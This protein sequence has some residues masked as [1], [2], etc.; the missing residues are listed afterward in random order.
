M[1]VFLY[2][3]FKFAFQGFLRNI[4]LSIVTIVILVLTLFS[5][6]TVSGVNFIAEQAIASVREKVDVS[7]YFK[8]A[9]TEDQV[10]NVRYRLE[11]LAQ[12]KAVTYVSKEE[13]LQKFKAKHQNEQ[14]IIDSVNQLETNPLPATL[15]VKAESIDDYPAIV[16]VLDG[17]DYADLIQE[18]NFADNQKV[19]SRLGELS[20]KVRTVG[21]II[22][23]VFIVIAILIIFNTIRINIYTHREEIGIMKLVGATNWFVRVPFLVE[24]ILYAL[25]GVI[26]C[27]AIL[28]PLL[29]VIAPQ[30]NAF[31]IGYDLD[32]AQ[33]FTSHF[34]Q[35][36]GWQLMFAVVLSMISSSIAIGRYLRV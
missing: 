30:I 12:V 4:W 32:I 7:V 11:Q 21:L 34:W 1:L 9:V 19:I 25:F 6:T 27:A 20:E 17:T 18:K 14:S 24:S 5:V 3:T 35:I 10:L 16:A 31:F 29:G 2:R 13:A 15:I 8:P 23:A 28:Y 33:Y 36:V 26:I 22:S